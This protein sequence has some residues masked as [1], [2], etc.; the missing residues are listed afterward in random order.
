[1]SDNHASWGVAAIGRAGL[2]SVELHESVPPA[3]GA[4]RLIMELPGAQLMILLASRSQVSALSSFLATNWGRTRSRE[5]VA[6]GRP[7]GGATL[8][9]M[10]DEIRIGTLRI[11]KDGELPDRFTGQVAGPD[12]RLSLDLR[13]PLIRHL[14]DALQDLERGLS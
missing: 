1:M 14:I 12:H 3:P 2:V 9:S 4:W 7:P 10:V 6:G 5:V 13:D 11:A 8:Y